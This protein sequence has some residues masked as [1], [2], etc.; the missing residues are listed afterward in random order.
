M[1]FRET[2][3]GVV[4]LIGLAHDKEKWRALLNTVMNF[5]VP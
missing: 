1:D 3:R 2:G 5:Q 4:H